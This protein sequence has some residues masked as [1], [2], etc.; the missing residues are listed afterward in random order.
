MTIKYANNAIGILASSITNVATSLALVAGY[1][2]K[3]PTV[4]F[5]VDGTF[6]YAAIEDANNNIEIIQ[7]QVHG[8]GSDTFSTIVRAQDGTSALAWSSGVIMEPRLTAAASQ[9]FPQLDPANAFTAQN[10]FNTATPVS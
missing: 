2:A 10:T 1:G 5:P 3:F 9:H 7:V 8:S 4:N 6:F